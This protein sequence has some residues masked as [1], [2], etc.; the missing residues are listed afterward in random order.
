MGA[1]LNADLRNRAGEDV[2]HECGDAAV[3]VDDGPRRKLVGDGCGAAVA[4][5]L[6]EGLD[7][8]VEGLQVCRRPGQGQARR[9]IGVRG[10]I[11]ATVFAGALRP[12]LAGLQ[13]RDL[14]GE[15]L[16]EG[17]DRDVRA[18]LVEVAIDGQQLRE[19]EMAARLRGGKDVLDR[20]LSGRASR[21]EPGQP[22][23]E[24]HCGDNVRVGAGHRRAADR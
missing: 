2:E 6:R 16:L 8:H 20:E 7:A 14:H 11:D 15:R 19:P 12:L 18:A 4:D 13:N 5:E 3:V 17:F 23:D 1:H 22:M 10:E 21:V 24:R 9:A